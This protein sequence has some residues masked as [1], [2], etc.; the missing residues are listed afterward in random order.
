[1]QDGQTPFLAAT[2]MGHVEVAGFLLDN[3]SS[4]LEQADVSG[5][6]FLG[7]HKNELCLAMLFVIRAYS[8]H[9]AINAIMLSFSWI[10]C[11]SIAK[12][13]VVSLYNYYHNCQ[14]LSMLYICSVIVQ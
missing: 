11:E 8:Y 3:G 7:R 10:T 5:Y 4:I 2:A 13:K 6:H 12:A 1:M 9:S 14:I